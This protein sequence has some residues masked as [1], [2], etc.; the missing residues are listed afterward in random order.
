MFDIRQFFLARL[1][2]D[3]IGHLLGQAECAGMADTQAQAPEIRCADL[4]LNIFEP[5]VA[6]IAPALLK[7]DAAGGQVELVVDDENLFWG[8]L[9]EIGQCR[10]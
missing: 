8:N 4:G 2:Q 5:I 3:E 1:V 7:A 10:H 9:V 6:A